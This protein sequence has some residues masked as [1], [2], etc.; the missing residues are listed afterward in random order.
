MSDGLGVALILGGAAL[1]LVV[2]FALWR[3]V[4]AVVALA[5][6]S[7]CTAAVGAGGLLVQEEAGA[8]SWVIALVTLGILG[9]LHGR[10][11]CGPPG[12][13]R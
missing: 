7:A 6:L 9:P 4:P 2:M 5:L 12:P 1:G 11:V 8:G 13:G 10:L 3:R